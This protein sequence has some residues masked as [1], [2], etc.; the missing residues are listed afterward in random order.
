MQFQ[1]QCLHSETLT[2]K[3]RRSFV[4]FRC[5]YNRHVALS[6]VLQGNVVM[7]QYGQPL[8]PVFDP[9]SCSLIVEVSNCSPARFCTPVRPSVTALTLRVGASTAL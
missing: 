1:I 2:V 6:N 9:A 4:F 8:H 5:I 3:Q 7:D